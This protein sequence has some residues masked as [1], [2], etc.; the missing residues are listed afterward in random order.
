MSRPR[1]LPLLRRLRPLAL[2]LAAAPALPLLL[3]GCG[4]AAPSAPD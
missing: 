4:Q 1:R 3:S 2:L